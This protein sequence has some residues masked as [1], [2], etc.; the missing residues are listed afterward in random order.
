MSIFS[1]AGIPA[2]YGICM[3]TTKYSI[4]VNGIDMGIYEGSSKDEAILAYIKDAGYRSIEDAAAA[5]SQSVERFRAE[6]AVTEA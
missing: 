3:N 2:C 1:C 6:L 4:S 5:L